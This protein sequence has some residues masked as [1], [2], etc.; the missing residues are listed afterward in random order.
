MLFKSFWRRRDKARDA[1][2]T[3]DPA[4][5]GSAEQIFIA[6]LTHTSEYHLERLEKLLEL[7]FQKHFGALDDARLRDLIHFASRIQDA[8][9]QRELLL[10]YLNCPPSI[11]AYLRSGDIVDESHLLHRAPKPWL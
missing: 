9:I 6:R 11:Q 8:D 7:R 4:V 2:P 1:E 5:S 10:F 3:A